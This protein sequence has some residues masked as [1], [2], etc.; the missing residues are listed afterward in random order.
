MIKALFWDNDGVLVDTEGL[1]FLATREVLA[2]VGIDLTREEFI[3]LFLVQGK[4]A[5]H[6]VRQRGF[7]P[8]AVEQLRDERNALYS[9]LLSQEQVVM[10]GVRDVLT[11]LRSKYTMGVVTSSRREHFE[12]MHQSTGLLPYFSFVIAAGDYT[13]SK[14]DPEPYL[15]AVERS[16][17]SREECLAI[18]D[19]ERGLASAS[20][21]G[22]RCI[23]V[24][25]DLTRGSPFAGAHRVVGSIT[26]ILSEL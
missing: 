1:Y 20:A 12:L 9:R 22:I 24:P 10:E 15:L 19:S 11:E 13:K 2:K 3:S 7:S 26:D 23:I 21:A 18:E 17:F 16:C 14:P 4:G 25:T 5:W 8:P 6:L